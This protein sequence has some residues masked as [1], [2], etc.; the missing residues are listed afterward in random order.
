MVSM[1]TGEMER[2]LAEWSGALEDA[3]AIADDEVVAL[4]GMGTGY[5]HLSCGRMDAARIALDDAIARSG[6]RGDDFLFAFTTAI[7][8]L[9]HFVT[10]DAEGG[11]SLVEQA[12][13]I[14]VRLGDFEGGGVALSFLAQMTFAKGDH[15]RA[16][17]CYRE[18]L[19]A[20]ETIGD[21]PEIA[22]VHCELGWTA[23]AHED[24]PESRRAF[25][26][27]LRTYD[28]VGS[29]RGIGL[30]LMGLAATEAAE[31]RADRA[32]TIAAAAHVMSERAGIVVEHP[33]APGLTDRIEALKATISTVDLD[34]LV[35]SGRAL[36]PSAVLAMVAS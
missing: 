32:V 8:G 6:A 3:R 7:K 22:R 27:A 2:G 20:F 34:A 1:S 31:G 33:M 28:E 18:A 14:Q 29:P 15:A 17:E 35:A 25:Q 24:V 21:R 9:L 26:R 16:I 13:T 30:A 11:M 12:R 10:G 36:S 23:L 19:A 5:I 4:A